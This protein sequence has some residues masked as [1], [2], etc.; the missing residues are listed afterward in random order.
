MTA[1]VESAGS[2]A[3]AR[4]LLELCV[5]RFSEKEERLMKL[6]KAINPLLDDDSQVALTYI[7]D[8]ILS[9]KIKSMPDSWPFLKPVNK[10]NVKDYYNVIQK[11]MDLEAIERSVKGHKYHTGSAFLGDIELIYEN[12]RKYNGM[13][14]PFTQKALAIYNVAKESLSQVGPWHHFLHYATDF[15][16]S[17]RCDE[18]TTKCLLVITIEG[19]I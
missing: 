15:S 18:K 12:S 4:N 6:E 3:S 10:K 19:T 16:S 1:I 13:D 7:L 14:S 11:P 2:T 5:R 9:S 8:N 17:Y